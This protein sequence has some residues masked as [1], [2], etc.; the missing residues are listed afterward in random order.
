MI[1]NV[2]I[3]ENINGVYAYV[4][5]MPNV[6]VLVGCQEEVTEAIRERLAFY[7][8]GLNNAIVKVRQLEYA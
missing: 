4:E 8:N 2:I 7:A 5:D 1:V 3:E 6:S